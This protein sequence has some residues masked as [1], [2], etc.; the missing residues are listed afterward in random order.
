[1]CVTLCSTTRLATSPPYAL[2]R[3]ASLGELPYAAGQAQASRH[4]SPRQDPGR[5]EP[6]HWR[7]GCVYPDARIFTES[8]PRWTADRLASRL[9]TL[10]R[11]GQLKEANITHVLSVLRLPTD[12]SYFDP[13][14]GR[15]H[16]LVEIDDVEDENLLQYF[17]TTNGFIQ[18]GLDGGGGVLV[19]WSVCFS[20]FL[21]SP[22]LVSTIYLQ[23]LGMRRICLTTNRAPA[24]KP[25]RF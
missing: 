25:G 7:V 16:L 1:M 10:R 8:W 4:G 18:E 6:V 14:K 17:V 12:S 22:S 23:S 13:F 5:V 11:R 9:F 2:H 21:S 3:W 24:S 15:K 19:H 20:G